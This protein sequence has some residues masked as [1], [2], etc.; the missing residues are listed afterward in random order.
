MTSKVIPIRIRW[1]QFRQPSLLSTT[2]VT[3]LKSKIGSLSNQPS[4]G[5]NHHTR[6]RMV[7]R[8]LRWV[9]ASLISR[10]NRH[11]PWISGIITI[12]IL[13]I[14][15]WSR[16]RFCTPSSINRGL[17]HGASRTMATSHCLSMK[18]RSSPESMRLGNRRKCLELMGLGPCSNHPLTN[19][20]KQIWCWVVQ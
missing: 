1:S 14:Q 11:A 5:V 13:T 18:S 3:F 10:S 12:Q 8:N 17:E 7:G 16:R 4:Q 19:I 20:M 2:E 15:S 6:E 9:K